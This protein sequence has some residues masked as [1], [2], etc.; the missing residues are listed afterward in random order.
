MAFVPREVRFAGVHAVTGWR[1]KAYE[2]VAAGQS[3]GPETRT[4]AWE[5]VPQL[6]A[7]PVDDTPR[8]DTFSE[9]STDTA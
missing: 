4:A 6:L 9:G 5:A 3:I 2:L 8:A 1:L 7:T